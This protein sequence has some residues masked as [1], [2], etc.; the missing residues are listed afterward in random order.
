MLRLS[1]DL[2]DTSSRL[3]LL[4]V[5]LLLS[6][7]VRVQVALGAPLAP[8]YRFPF[9]PALV[10]LVLVVLFGTV[11][12]NRLAASPFVAAIF[13]TA[14]PF[15]HFIVVVLVSAVALLLLPD[16][17]SLQVLYFVAIGLLLGILS[18][19][20]PRR[21]YP[22]FSSRAVLKDLH[23]VWTHRALLFLWLSY[24]IQTRY[25]QRI[26]GILWIILLPVATSLVIA[27]AFSQFMRIDIGVPFIAFYMSALLPYNFLSNNLFN[28]TGA[29]LS[30]VGIITQVYF[31]REILVFLPLGETLVD[32][33]FA[34][35][36]ML[37]I[38]LFSGIVPSIYFLY[39][40]LLFAVLA[41]MTIGLM[42]LISAVTVVVR[43]IPQLLSVG[44]QLLFFLTPVI[45]PIEQVPERFRFLFL[46]NPLAP[47]IQGFRDIIAF[48][49][50]PD[51]LSLGFSLACA[52]VFLTIGY[53]VFKAL[54]TEMTDLL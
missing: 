38:N 32:F 54:E 10:A 8:D 11:A 6:L 33:V 16:V 2:Y 52:V 29:V 49:R 26:L 31:P 4:V 40:P 18:I 37:V 53:A 19:A 22:P 20:L 7:Q 30:R 17:S 21:L 35:A 9:L 3:V 39:L 14:H 1:G 44:L 12:A 15:R 25:N 34:F 36:A 5:A 51:L 45:Y 13:G 41:V 42:F 28:S 47:I 48:R 24:N 27:F 46:V 43:D 50:A 23:A